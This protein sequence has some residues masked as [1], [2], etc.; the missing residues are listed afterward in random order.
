[1]ALFCKL[2]SSGSGAKFACGTVTGGFND[3]THV[4]KFDFVPNYVC[5]MLPNYTDEL[6]TPAIVYWR[7]QANTWECNSYSDAVHN[8]YDGSGGS[9][10]AEITDIND[11]QMT[12]V[13]HGYSKDFM[14]IAW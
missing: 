14:W 9:D 10:M 8:Y 11:T 13:V 4:V 6:R 12:I 1:M 2:P 3:T 5:L 7:E